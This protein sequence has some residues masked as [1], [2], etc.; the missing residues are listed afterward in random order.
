MRNAVRSRLTYA[1]VMATGA[2]FIALGGGAY[3]LSGVPD[4]GGVYH[5][6]V[7]KSGALRVVTTGFFVPEDQDRQTRQAT[8]PNPRRNGD[9]VEPEGAAGTSRHPGTSRRAGTSRHAGPARGKRRHPRR[10]ASRRCFPVG[11][12]NEAV[13]PGRVGRGRWWSR[14]PTTAHLIRSEPLDAFGLPTDGAVPHGWRADAKAGADDT[15][16]ADVAAWVICVSP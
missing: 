3:A 16:D 13:Q 11:R 1:N 6:C 4:R 9:R 15:T 10:Y 2:M 5:G 8:C 14:I 12:V 7:A